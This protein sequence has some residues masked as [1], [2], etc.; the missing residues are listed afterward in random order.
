MSTPEIR[1]IVA[2]WGMCRWMVNPC[3]QSLKG[4]WP[5]MPENVTLITDEYI[6]DLPSYVNI[7]TAPAWEPRH[8]SGRLMEMLKTTQEP[9]IFLLS[10]DTFL[11]RNIDDT[12]MR[13]LA[14]YMVEKGNIFSAVPRL[15][16]ALEKYRRHVDDYHGMEIIDCGAP[17]HCSVAGAAWGHSLYSRDLLLRLLENFWTIWECETFTM[18]KVKEDPSVTSVGVYPALFDVT[19]LCWTNVGK[20]YSYFWHLDQ[21]TEYDRWL[22]QTAMPETARWM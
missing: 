15:V 5:E 22:V 6:G 2:A 1:I 16:A 18:R 11:T 7:Y 21:L 9:I 20:T 8:Y 4:H 17:R 14:Q 10:V 19:D 3:I 12:K 13:L